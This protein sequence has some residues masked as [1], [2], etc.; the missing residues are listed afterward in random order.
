ML[1][2]VSS[3]P[4]ISTLSRSTH[5]AAKHSKISLEVVLLYALDGIKFLKYD[6]PESEIMVL[7]SNSVTVAMSCGVS[8]IVH[9]HFRPLKYNPNKYVILLFV[10]A[11]SF[12]S[13]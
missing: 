6:E 3:H 2:A 9:R 12:V 13:S 10:F 11:S 8:H 4:T 1:T 5:R 7:F